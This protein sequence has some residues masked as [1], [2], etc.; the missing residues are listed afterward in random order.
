MSGSLPLTPDG[1]GECHAGISR[2]NQIVSWL[3]RHYQ[4]V[5]IAIA[6]AHLSGLHL[7]S[8]FA[9]G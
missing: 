9:D 1:T 6:I 8:A 5:V 4:L 3:E 7:Q 2:V